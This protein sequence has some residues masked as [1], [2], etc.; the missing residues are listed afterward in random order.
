MKNLAAAGNTC[1][2]LDANYRGDRSLDRLDQEKASS[3]LKVSIFQRVDYFRSEDGLISCLLTYSAARHAVPSVDE[4]SD[5]SDQPPTTASLPVN[6]CTTDLKLD[7][8]ASTCTV[9]MIFTIAGFASPPAVDMEKR[10][11]MGATH[12]FCVKKSKATTAFGGQTPAGNLLLLIA[13]QELGH[14]L[15]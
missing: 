13:G 8:S 14:M 7:R 5:P 10:F 2:I 12:R 1:Y 11:W 3:A 6:L 15:K 9:S 4:H